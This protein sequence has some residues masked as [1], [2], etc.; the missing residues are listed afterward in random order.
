MENH[1]ELAEMVSIGLKRAY[2]KMIE[3]KKK[4]NSPIIVSRNGKIVELPAT[5]I[6]QGNS[7]PQ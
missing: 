4:S 6:K 3:F 2:S 1:S 5:D 7:E